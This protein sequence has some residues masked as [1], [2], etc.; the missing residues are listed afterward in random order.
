MN[1]EPVPYRTMTVDELADAMSE[2]FKAAP[3]PERTMRF[4]TGP[5]GHAMIN[6]A[7]RKEVTR[8]FAKGLY[9]EGSIT[10]AKYK[11]LLAMI[12]SPDNESYELAKGIIE[13]ITK[14]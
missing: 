10:K 13:T 6:D 9:E 1:I 4:H 2:I 5:E 12:D 7:I 11:T 8:G 14:T 3:K